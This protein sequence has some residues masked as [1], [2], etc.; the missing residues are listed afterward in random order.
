MAEA[1]VEVWEA[2]RRF[3]DEVAD[4]VEVKEQQ[5]TDRLRSISFQPT[6]SDAAPVWLAI[7][8]WEVVVQIGKGTRFELDVDER[9]RRELEELL[10]AAAGGRVEETTR[11]L[12]LAFRVWLSDGTVKAG[13]VMGRG[14]GGRRATRR[15]A[16]WCPSGG[17]SD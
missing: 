5:L 14:Y 15:Y 8:Q 12:W 11:R 2:V 4:L 17:Q 9:G 3:Q 1:E 6:N 16:P 7:S 13:R 10:R